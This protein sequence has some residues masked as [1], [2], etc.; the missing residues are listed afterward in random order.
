M[1]RSEGLPSVPGAYLSV[2]AG[3]ALVGEDG[4]NSEELLAAADV[5]MYKDKA[6]R[7]T[8]RAILPERAGL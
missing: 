7:K 5:A 3:V 8:G 4:T 6:T 2:S 1:L